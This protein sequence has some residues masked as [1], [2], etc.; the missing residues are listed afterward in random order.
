MN[1]LYI[2]GNGFDLAHGLKT[3]YNDFL[4]WYLR[5]SLYLK[6][7]SETFTDQLIKIEG[8]GFIRNGSDLDQIN[9]ISKFFNVLESFGIQL[10][11]INTFITGIISKSREFNWV[12]IESEYYKIVL[13]HSKHGSEN[14]GPIK[15]LNSQF[16]YLKQRLV[17]YLVQLPKS[18]SQIEDV[19]HHFVP[20]VKNIKSKYL[21]LNFNY[22]STIEKYISKAQNIEI[23]NIHGKL[24]DPTNEV[25]FGYGD[26]M[27]GDYGKLESINVD[28][29]LKNFKSFGYLKNNN[30]RSLLEFINS[31]EYNV[32]IMGHSCGLSDRVLLSSIFQHDNCSEI[33]ICYHQKSQA[34]DDHYEKTI[35]ISRHFSQAMKA[36]M[37][38]RIRPKDI[39]SPLVRLKL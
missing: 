23:M 21:I 28:E 38:S 27:H 29:Y 10:K 39:S 4:L 22:T 8:P 3:S 11:P 32:E 2:I 12:D 18:I 6:N 33:E 24:N 13:L 34:E 1:T 37:R 15:S 9:S 17:E 26:E 5:E 30:Y 16:D 7:R 19:S 20:I 35:R 36:E 14:L 25:I 31:D